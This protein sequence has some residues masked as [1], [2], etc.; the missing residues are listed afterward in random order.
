MLYGG[1]NDLEVLHHA[2]AGLLVDDFARIRRLPDPAPQILERALALDP[3]HRFQTAAEFADEVAVHMGGGRIGAGQLLRELFG[4]DF[5]TDS[6]LPAATV[7]GY[8]A[9]P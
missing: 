6:A 2:A 3:N 1:N 7:V 8:T 5:Q 9:G 4:R